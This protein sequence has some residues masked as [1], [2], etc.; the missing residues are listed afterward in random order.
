MVSPHA[1]FV[2]FANYNLCIVVL[3]YLNIVIDS[4]IT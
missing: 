4:H 2:L 3:D 1:D